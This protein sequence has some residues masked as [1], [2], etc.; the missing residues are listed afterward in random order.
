M[1][2]LL[3][4]VH[5]HVNRHLSWPSLY[6]SDSTALVAF[7][8]VWLAPF[9]CVAPLAANNL[10]SGLKLLVMCEYSKFRIKSNSYLLLDSI[11]NWRNYSKFS[12]TYLMVISGA[13]DMQFV[14]TLPATSRCTQLSVEPS[15]APRV[16]LPLP[17]PCSRMHARSP[18]R[19]CMLP[20]PGLDRGI[21]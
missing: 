6:Y 1:F 7:I 8:I 10:Q 14:C 13:I 20:A 12:N 15:A 18:L 21:W 3:V 11:R 19:A 17:L 5:V 16:F 2:M 4:H 9:H